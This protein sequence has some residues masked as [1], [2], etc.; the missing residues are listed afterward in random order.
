MIFRQPSKRNQ[1]PLRQGV[2][3]I[4]TK[5]N[6]TKATRHP[7]LIVRSKSWKCPKAEKLNKAPLYTHCQ[8]RAT[9]PQEVESVLCFS[10][11]IQVID[12]V[13]PKVEVQRTVDGDDTHQNPQQIRETLC[14]I[15]LKP[16]HEVLN[17]LGKRKRKRTPQ[18]L[19]RIHVEL[20][21]AL[22]L[23]I[24]QDLV[25]SGGDDDGIG[26]GRSL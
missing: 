9:Y 11:I 4:L 20:I 7:G 17:W 23:H 6:R 14:Q 13:Y 24:N 25:R 26:D 3:F 8:K 22:V 2:H 18:H 12:V 10:Q 21:R 16:T 1:W 15:K 5:F 19:R